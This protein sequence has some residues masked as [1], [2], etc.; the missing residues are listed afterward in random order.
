MSSTGANEPEQP[1]VNNNHSAQPPMAN[2]RSPQNTVP[3]TNAQ[4]PMDAPAS[5]NITPKVDTSNVQFNLP[6]AHQD[7]VTTQST[8]PT[9]SNAQT[10]KVADGKRRGGSDS[11]DDGA[12]EVSSTFRRV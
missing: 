8:Q 10:G 1:N 2:D 3:A 9:A 5:A 11:E 6:N 4:P 12:E 7:V